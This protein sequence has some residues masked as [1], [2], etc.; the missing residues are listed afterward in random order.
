MNSMSHAIRANPV[1]QTSFQQTAVPPQVRQT[2]STLAD[3][4][5]LRL[6]TVWTHAVEAFIERRTGALRDGVQ[7]L[8]VANDRRMKVWSLRIPVEL[9]ARVA[10][11]AADDGLQPTRVYCTAL[12]LYAMDC[13]ECGVAVGPMG[14][15]PTKSIACKLNETEGDQASTFHLGG[16]TVLG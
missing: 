13:V 11:I 4:Q 2:L 15:R 14:R 5:A 6:H 7:L 3:T 12:T 8:Y 10:H 16:D 9:S 1:T